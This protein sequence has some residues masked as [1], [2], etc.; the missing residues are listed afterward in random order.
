MNQISPLWLLR[1]FFASL[2]QVAAVCSSLVQQEPALDSPVLEGRPL[3]VEVQNPASCSSNGHIVSFA[4]HINS[5]V[6][7]R[8]RF[9]KIALP[10]SEPEKKKQVH[11]G[12][13][14]ARQVKA[15][16]NGLTK[17]ASEAATPLKVILPELAPGAGSPSKITW[18]PISSLLSGT[19]CSSSV[20][21]PSFTSFAS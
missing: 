9:A 17:G 7:A 13:A 2:G 15:S 8:M 16:I 4:W 6:H 14:R 19:H 1:R 20:P 3:L 5:H 12:Q 11:S 10:H 18:Q 21:W